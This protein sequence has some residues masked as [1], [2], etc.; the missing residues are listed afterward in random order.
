MA[1]EGYWDR[2]RRSRLS[3]R[4]ALVGA[5]GLGVGAVA[6]GTVGCGG[7]GDDGGGEPEDASGLLG[8]RE[9]TSSQAKP[10]GTSRA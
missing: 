1:A 7:G 5:T 3:R 6:L 8:V 9:D 10:G 2:F 4:R